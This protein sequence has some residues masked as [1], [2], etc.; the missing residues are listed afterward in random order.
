MNYPLL[1]GLHQIPIIS[2]GF[3]SLG[4]TE[5]A[6]NWIKT[7]PDRVDFQSNPSAMIAR[8]K[9]MSPTTTQIDDGMEEDLQ[10]DH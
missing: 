1:L 7:L 9:L 2:I 4:I 6:Y 5:L 10:L 8:P 3:Q